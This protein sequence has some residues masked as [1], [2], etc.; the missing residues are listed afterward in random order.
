MVGLFF[1]LTYP[2][3]YLFSLRQ[4]LYPQL[5]IVRKI[6]AFFPS[7]FSGIFYKIKY[8]EKIDWTK[9][10]IVCP[11]HSS[12]MDIFAASLVVKNNFFYLGKEELLKNPITARYFKTIDIP[13]NRDS[14]IASFR[15]FK[16]TSERIAKGMTAVIFP[17]GKIG[18][19]Y[20]P[21]LHEFKNG[22]FRLA[23]EHQISIIPV[24][25][26][27]NWRLC[28][29][30]GKVYGVKPGISAV[31]VHAPIDTT[32]M[33]LEDDERLKEL[34]YQKINSKLDYKL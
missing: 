31:F 5:N 6:C 4:S 25:I 16:K 18:D 20:P 28:W 33:K 26:K 21:L 22:P 23:I 2:F 1:A 17:E 32:G 7:A 29:D 24:S 34:V 30:D 13:I 9:T 14:K 10:Y 8:E 15:A 12:N 19:E 11:N 27:D 3:L